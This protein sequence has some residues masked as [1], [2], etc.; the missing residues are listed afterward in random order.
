[1]SLTRSWADQ[2]LRPSSP[3]RPAEKSRRPRGSSLRRFLGYVRPYLSLILIAT[4]CG[5]FKLCVPA[6][7]AIA[8]SYVID[9][10]VPGLY[11]GAPAKRHDPTYYWAVN[12]VNW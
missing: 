10:L 6:T 11:G 7:M 12:F 4:V 1:M 2:R 9:H 5:T 8:Q 3:S